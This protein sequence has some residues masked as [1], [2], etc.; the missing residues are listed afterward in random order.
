[1]GGGDAPVPGRTCSQRCST[2]KKSPGVGRYLPGPSP[3]VTHAF[4]AVPPRRISPSLISPGRTLTVECLRVRSRAGV[5]PGRGWSRLSVSVTGVPLYRFSCLCLPLLVLLCLLL[6]TR[7][8]NGLG[9][10][11][12]R[13]VAVVRRSLGVPRVGVRGT[14][15]TPS[16]SGRWG[17]SRVPICKLSFSTWESGRMQKC[18]K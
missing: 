13:G 6:W 1:M 17:L 9:L 7:C 2:L 15:L 5:Q 4:S 11:S 14:L 12:P 3:P 18:K 10:G 8:R 16:C